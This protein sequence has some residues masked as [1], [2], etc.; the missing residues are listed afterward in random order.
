MKQSV[1]HYYLYGETRSHPG[2]ELIHI[3]T[4]AQRGST[5]RW[6]IKPHRHDS[7]LQLFWVDRGSML[8]TI[9]TEEIRVYGESVLLVP[10]TVVHGF[11]VSQAT[12]GL[13]VTIAD[14]MLQEVLNDADHG[15]LAQLLSAPKFLP[16]DLDSHASNTAVR[17][18]RELD[19]EYRRSRPARISAMSAVCK[20]LLV[21]LVRMLPAD[22]AA[23]EA[24][25]EAYRQ[26]ER[27]RD[28]LEHHYREQW[29]VKQYA[30]SLGV[31]EKRLTRFCRQTSDLSPLQIVHNRQ[32]T[33]AKRWL[34]YTEKSINEIAYDLGFKDPAYFS[35]FFSK[36][37]GHQASQFRREHQD[38]QRETS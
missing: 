29:T 24:H 1:P 16:I 34:V 27:F 10:P 7:L 33:E 20:L 22:T 6:E 3:E 19:E 15:D 12:A 2:L 4:I 14:A 31:S 28:L 38:S 8:A 35:R 18:I 21:N 13:V 9:D 36:M 11:K 17:L 23:D 25:G 26:Y 30:D 32:L 5:N 37:T